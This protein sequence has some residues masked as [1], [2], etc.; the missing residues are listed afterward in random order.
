MTTNTTL[1]KIGNS[2]GVIIPSKILK[3]L[4]LSAKDKV[5]IIEENGKIILYKPP[6]NEVQTPFSVLDTWYDENGYNQNGC[7]DDALEYIA[8]LR[9]DRN[10]KNVP[11]W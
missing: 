3:T 2:T 11:Q 5:S 7:A 8:T 10:N 1:V 4:S 9:A 6:K